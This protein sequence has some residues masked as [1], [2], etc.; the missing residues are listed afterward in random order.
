MVDLVFRATY[1]ATHNTT[2]VEESA[3]TQAGGSVKLA[4]VDLQGDQTADYA[5]PW[6]ISNEARFEQAQAGQ[7]QPSSTNSAN[8]GDDMV[9]TNA[10]WRPRSDAPSNSGTTNSS[11]GTTNAASADPASATST[12]LPVTDDQASATA[13]APTPDQVAH[14]NY[15]VDHLA[16]V[17]KASDG[18]TVADF[19]GKQYSMVPDTY[20]Q[21]VQVGDQVYNKSDN[22]TAFAM[23]MKSK[24]TWDMINDS[25]TWGLSADDAAKWGASGSRVADGEQ[26]QNDGSYSLNRD[27]SHDGLVLRYAVQS[28]AMAEQGLIGYVD[29]EGNHRLVSRDLQPE[30]YNYLV[31]EKNLG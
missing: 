1:D 20:D 13:A 5:D 17:S 27:A 26:G 23:T 11:A 12:A 6:A 21:A 3:Y 29:Q 24:Q 7:H 14:A 18:A 31:T 4:S 28:D 9:L 19:Q 30:L 16:G 22:P 10:G 8:G 2:H 25:S 15:V